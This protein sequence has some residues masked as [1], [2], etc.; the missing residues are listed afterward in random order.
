MSNDLEHDLRE[1][2]AADA[3]AA[4]AVRDL[5]AAA[6]GKAHAAVRRQRRAA[7]VASALT[8]AVIVGGFALL[9]GTG[10]HDSA[11]PSSQHPAPST[12]TSGSSPSPSVEPTVDEA[13]ALY[14]A[15]VEVPVPA[16]MLTA[17]VN[18]GAPTADAA[19]VVGFDAGGC[20]ANAID[21]PPVTT[22]VLQPWHAPWIAQPN[23]GTHV[24]ADGRT[25]LVTRVPG[26]DLRF[27]VTSPDPKRAEQ[28]FS[29]LKIITMAHGCPVRDTEDFHQVPPFASAETPDGGT[30]CAYHEG[31]LVGSSRMTAQQ[32]QDVTGL[33][34]ERLPSSDPCL[35]PAGPRIVDDWRVHLRFPTEERLLYVPFQACT[36]TDLTQRLW[37]LATP[38][39][40][41]LRS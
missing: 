34:A 7:G 27:I 32:S 5:A 6:R 23:V 41:S 17:R 10:G 30:V 31:W 20:P 15:D 28:V 2:F 13:P 38:P 9:L 19:Y 29:G 3:A 12:R 21:A 39:V 14:Y 1:L 16:A 26:A 37:D 11:P 4:P 22:V 33:L 24:L 35:S 18:C 36:G 8:A 25:Q 40:A